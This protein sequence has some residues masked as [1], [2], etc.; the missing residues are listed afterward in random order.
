MIERACL[1]PVLTPTMAPQGVEGVKSQ[2]IQISN[3]DVGAG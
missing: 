2:L 3:W 1:T